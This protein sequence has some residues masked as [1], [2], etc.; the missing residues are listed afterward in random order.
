M[1]MERSV[2]ATT[3]GGPPEFVEPEAGILVRPGDAA[4]LT[5]AL[6]QAAALASPNHAAR[7]VAAVHDVH[8]QAT[9]M[10]A[11]LQRAVAGARGRRGAVSRTLR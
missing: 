1:A 3:V 6:Q 4:G 10:A 8:R 2:V 9:R 11:V 5:L 7:R